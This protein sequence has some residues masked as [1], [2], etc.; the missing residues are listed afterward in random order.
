MAFKL[1][2]GTTG[3]WSVAGNWIPGGAPGSADTAILSGGGSYTVTY[4]VSGF[5]SINGLIVADPGATL[6]FGAGDFLDVARNVALTAGTINV[7]GGADLA[8]GGDVDITSGTVDLGGSGGLFAN[9]NIFD[10][11]LIHGGDGLN[12]L[13]LV[14]DRRCG[15]R[16]G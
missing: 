13:E 14:G 11:G 8:A 2:N 4:D 15:G 5:G 16:C 1:W 3:N 10:D 6:D 9:T 7:L 12:I